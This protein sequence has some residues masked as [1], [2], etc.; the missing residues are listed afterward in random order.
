MEWRVGLEGYEVMAVHG[1]YD[2]EHQAAQPFIFTVWATLEQRSS[3]EELNE[4]LNYADLQLAIDHVMLEC[5]RPIRLMEEMAK[6]VIGIVAKHI[7]VKEI[8]VRIEK[9]QA[10]LPHPGGLP[11]I[12]AIWQRT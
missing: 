10:P 8:S 1:F 6:N 11:V 3:I 5:E 4:T 7:C 9:P 2:Y 12:E